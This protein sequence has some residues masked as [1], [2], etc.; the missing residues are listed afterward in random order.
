MK[1]GDLWKEVW[2]K[3]DSKSGKKTKA[4]YPWKCGDQ[5]PPNWFGGL[6]RNQKSQK[7]INVPIIFM[8]LLFKGSNY[9]VN[10]NVAR[11]EKYR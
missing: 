4:Q 7:D 9:F 11:T 3:K 2:Q 10:T 5:K 1:I 8:T 6:K